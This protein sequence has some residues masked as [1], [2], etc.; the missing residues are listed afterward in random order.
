MFITL[1]FN[2]QLNFQMNYSRLETSH[3]PLISPR[4]ICL[5][6]QYAMIYSNDNQILCSFFVSLWKCIKQPSSRGGRGEGC[7]WTGVVC[8]SLTYALTFCMQKGAAEHSLE[9]SLG[10]PFTPTSSTNSVA[11]QNFDECLSSAARQRQQGPKKRMSP[12]GLEAKG[13]MGW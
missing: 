2:N 3:S 10:T 6:P 4:Y 5:S 9:C 7:R 13:S 11:C 12:G 1:L 8:K